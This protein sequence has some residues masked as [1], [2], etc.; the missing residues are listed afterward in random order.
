R[1]PCSSRGATTGIS[2]CLERLAASTCLQEIRPL[3][4]G[5]ARARLQRKQRMNQAPPQTLMEIEAREAPAVAARL[6]AQQAERLKELGGKLRALGPRYALAA[7]R[8]SSD[9]AALLAKYLFEIRLG[10]PTVSVA[11]SVHS[12]YGAQLQLEKALLLAISQ[13]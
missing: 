4:L 6:V 13:S 8:G 10:L 1:P 12:I 2:A 11:P 9:A 7:G 5:R 3:S